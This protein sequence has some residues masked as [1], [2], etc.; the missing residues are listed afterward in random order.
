MEAIESE[1]KK[2]IDSDFVREKQH[3]DCVANIVYV[4]KK[5]EKI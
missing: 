1:I 5:N 3:P 2:L 4:L